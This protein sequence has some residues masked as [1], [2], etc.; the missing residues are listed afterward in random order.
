MGNVPLHQF[1][2]TYRDEIIRRCRAKVA[3]RPIPLPT[4]AEINHGVPLFLDQLVSA[5]RL[6]LSSMPEIGPS[7]VLHGHDLLRRGFSVSQVVH[8]YGD[9]CQSVT[10]LAM[11][12][13]APISTDDFRTL[14]AC[15]DEAIAGA[16]TEYGRERNQSTIDR[17]YA[18]G[19]E[20]LGFQY[21][22]L[23]TLATRRRQRGTPSVEECT[24]RTPHLAPGLVAAQTVADPSAWPPAGACAESTAVT[25]ATRHGNAT[26]LA[27]C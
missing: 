23:S 7:S 1:I 2:A 12:M 9:V 16:V 8:D 22:L 13:G 19:S 17:E 4:E 18:R 3:T 10:D 21:S 24:A 11:E 15:L 27:R 20:R 6:G 25:P 5:L 14:N 26:K